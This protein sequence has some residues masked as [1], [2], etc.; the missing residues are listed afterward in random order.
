MTELL[1]SGGNARTVQRKFIHTSETIFN[2]SS[3]V[4]AEL[5]ES[6]ESANIYRRLAFEK[7]KFITYI[8]FFRFSS[9]TRNVS[10]ASTGPK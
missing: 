3:V 6:F 2:I 4:N 1:T 7:N 8:D 9:Y 10:V 5:L